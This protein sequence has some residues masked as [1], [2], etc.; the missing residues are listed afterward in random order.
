[1]SNYAY[2]SFLIVLGIIVIASGRYI[3]HHPR[4]FNPDIDRVP[5]DRRYRFRQIAHVMGLLC[6]FAGIL[7]IF[8][9]FTSL[10]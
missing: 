3:S 9:G 4:W 6:V 5:P 10:V 7:L 1:M 2:A 8:L